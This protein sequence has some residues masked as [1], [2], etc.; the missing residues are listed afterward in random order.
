[1]SEYPVQI[2]KVQAPPLR[3]ETL[4]RTRLLD[5]LHVKIHRRVVL[6]TAEAG[7]GKTTLLADFSGAAASAR[8][9]S[10]STVGIATGSGSWPTRG[11]RPDPLSRI[12]TGH[13]VAVARDRRDAPPRDT[14]LDTFIRELGDLPADPTALILD[15]VHAVDDSIDVRTI[16]RELLARAPERL[17][18]VLISRRCAGAARPV[19]APSA[20]WPSSERPSSGSTRWK[21]SNSSGRRTPWH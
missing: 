21:P 6:V 7:Y 14:V 20:R 9:G 13:A 2:G 19:S 18:F 10:V 5:W 16:L 3:D 1:M 8:S 11:V 17:T 12:R 15:D 4:E